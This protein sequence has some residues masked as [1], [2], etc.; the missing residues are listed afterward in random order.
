MSDPTI[1]SAE[2][3]A[4][5]VQAVLDRNTDALEALLAD[6]W[7]PAQNVAIEMSPLGWVLAYGTPEILE[8]ML[9]HG[10]DPNARDNLGIPVAHSVWRCTDG[11]AFLESLIAHGLDLTAATPRGFRI[12]HAAVLQD[13]GR[14]DAQAAVNLAE[15]IE[16]HPNVIDVNVRADDLSTPLM[17]ALGSQR[18]AAVA[19][20]LAAGARCDLE[21]GTGRTAIDML[22]ELTHDAP[23]ATPGSRGTNPQLLALLD[24]FLTDVPNYDLARRRG[25]GSTAERAIRLQSPEVIDVLLRHGLNP[26][27]VAYAFGCAGHTPLMSILT[28]SPFPMANIKFRLWARLAEN[29]GFSWDPMTAS[30]TQSKAMKGSK[31]VALDE[32]AAMERL[33]KIANDEALDETTRTAAADTIAIAEA[34]KTEAFIMDLYRRLVAGMSPEA[35]AQPSLET[36][37]SIAGRS[38]FEVAAMCERWSVVRDLAARAGTIASTGPNSVWVSFMGS[39]GSILS[40]DPF[41]SG[42]ESAILAKTRGNAAVTQR[43]RE[44]VAATLAT[45]RKTCAAP[46]GHALLAA[47]MTRNPEMIQTVLDLGA[48]ATPITMEG[49]VVPPPMVL[50]LSYT[51]NDLQAFVENADAA[52]ALKAWQEK[53]PGVAMTPQELKA[54][55]QTVP[56]FIEATRQ[57]NE[58]LAP[59]L[60]ALVAAGARTW[61]GAENNAWQVLSGMPVEAALPIWHTLLSDPHVRADRVGPDGM[62]LVHAVLMRGNLPLARALV[63]AHRDP[64]APKL[65]RGWLDDG[66]LHDL[67][68]AQVAHQG[69]LGVQRAVLGGLSSLGIAPAAIEA[70]DDAGNT[71]L[72]R[73]V[74]MGQGQLAMVLLSMGANP[75]AANDQGETPLHHAVAQSDLDLIRALRVNGADS[76]A[77]TQAGALPRDIAVRMGSQRILGVLEEPNPESPIRPI[78]PV[79]DEK[80]ATDT[81]AWATALATVPPPRPP[82]AAAI[83]RVMQ[84]LASSFEVKSPATAASPQS[85]RSP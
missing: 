68:D 8:W 22:V 71:P 51:E 40:P 52:A 62:T 84:R 14:D 75:N 11:V 30:L 55:M 41:V 47:I 3:R 15:F 81:T 31:G 17:V 67:V 9:A 70:R 57:R 83:G 85:S 79:T 39:M 50:L 74:A 33:D 37:S 28:R 25:W 10:L 63:R 38:A 54:T 16:K 24:Q 2:H 4:Q 73:A 65:L 19:P 64:S 5:M 27:T 36:Q 78:P 48:P 7:S 32:S 69:D 43:E 42:S 59:L 82:V 45:L 53:N 58:N 35:I 13:H 80:L 1:M 6:G 61:D 21:D 26:N 76:K 29:F 12:A 49:A 60:P 56:A 72:L 20:L 44:T 23:S 77:A 46:D 66:W 34:S 18:V